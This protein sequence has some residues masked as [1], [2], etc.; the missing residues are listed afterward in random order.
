M[1]WEL[2]AE[3]LTPEQVMAV[4]YPQIT[5]ADIQA[6]LAYGSAMS[7]ERCVTVALEAVA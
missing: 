1:V 6:C 4:H 3:G 5:L 7:H 2:L